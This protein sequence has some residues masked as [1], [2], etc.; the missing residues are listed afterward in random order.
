MIDFNIFTDK[1]DEWAELT[2][3][4]VLQRTLKNRMYDRLNQYDQEA[5]VKAV[6]TL[7]E[8]GTIP[9]FNVLRTEIEK[10]I[11]RDYDKIEK[12]HE[13]KHHVGVCE[14]RR[15]DLCNFDE[16][17]V[18]HEVYKYNLPRLIN[19]RTHDNAVKQITEAFPY[20]DF[21][22]KRMRNQNFAVKRNKIGE[23]EN[24]WPDEVKTVSE[25][26]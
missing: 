8:Q 1:L 21:N 15:C 20:M 14:D 18:Q 19:E 23:W 26:N 10:H 2:V 22:E 3:L 4:H 24:V 11:H 13:I 6:N 17:D 7:I 16:C 9:S 25:R 12:K 5:F